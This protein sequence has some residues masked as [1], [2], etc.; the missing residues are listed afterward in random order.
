[1]SKLRDKFWKNLKFY[2]V[3]LILN[4]YSKRRVKICQK[5]SMQLALQMEIAINSYGKI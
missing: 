4:H 3:C 2:L 5:L 1:M